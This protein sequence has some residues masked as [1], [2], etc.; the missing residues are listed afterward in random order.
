MKRLAFGIGSSACGLILLLAGSFAWALNEPSHSLINQ[1]ATSRSSL[2]A[3]LQE[4][5]GMPDGIRTPVR[6]TTE[7][8]RVE[9]WIQLGGE[10]EDESTLFEYVTGKARPFRHF[11]DPLRPW[12]SSG[13]FF[14][15][16][17]P[18][19]FTRYES[20]I[21]WAQRLDQERETGYGNYSW[22]HAR[23]Y[24]LTALTDTDPTVREQAFAN[25][26][27]ALGQIMHLIVDASVPEHVRNDAHPMGRLLDR[28]G[29]VG[30]YEYWVQAQHLEAGKELGFIQGFLSR[31]ITLDPA[32]LEIP[33]PATELIARVPIAR[34]FDSDRYTGTNPEV[35]SEARIGIAETANAN[36][37][38]E[39]TG[40]GEYPHPALA[41]MDKYVGIYSKLGE[42]RA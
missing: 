16:T 41:N 19:R 34:L 40:H 1:E 18:P 29:Q 21:R 9:Q 38:S 10:R 32:L 8:R 31:S 5:L 25:T 36:F 3:F 14:P 42:K 39:D 33:I 13:L 12:D 35:T 23:R 28:L 11:H 6:G 2:N 30:N 20:S 26:F 17:L 24:Y 37:L 7:S 27:Q 22:P 15:L 4:H